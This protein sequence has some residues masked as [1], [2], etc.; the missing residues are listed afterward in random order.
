MTNVSLF[1]F[2]QDNCPPCY[3]L[4]KFIQ[5]LPSEQ[6]DAIEVLNFKTPSG[7]RTALAEELNIELT[8]TL[9]VANEQ[10]SCELPDENDY[11][12]CSTTVDSIETIVGGQAITTALPGI[13]DNY[14]FSK[15]V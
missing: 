11:E 9:V 7:Q 13:I 5:T 4:K 2:T 6:Q 14:I 1:L 12:D 3:G 8:P 15:D 10:V